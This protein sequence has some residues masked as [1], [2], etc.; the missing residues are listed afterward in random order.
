MNDGIPDLFGEER[1]PPEVQ[2]SRNNPCETSDSRRPNF[3]QEIRPKNYWSRGR[4]R[5]IP[6]F[7]R[8][9][10]KTERLDGDR[11]PSNLSALNRRQSTTAPSQKW[12]FNLL[13][14]SSCL[15]KEVAESHE[16]LYEEYYSSHF[17]SQIIMRMWR[18]PV[19]TGTKEFRDASETWDTSY[20]L[21]PKSS[22]ADRARFRNSPHS[23]VYKR[24]C[25]I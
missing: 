14:I 19:A 7:N 5:I 4:I 13:L 17:S 6:W 18:K 12:L 1:T 25:M 20:K 10:F 15:K 16:N 24:I 11:D 8:R 23:P 2:I 3:N 22:I 9:R 21:S